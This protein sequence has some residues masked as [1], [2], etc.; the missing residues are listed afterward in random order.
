V[1][2]NPSR[3]LAEPIIQAIGVHKVYRNGK[4]EVP[5]LRGVDLTIG[6][7]EM[8]AI[9]GP[10]GC[11]KTTLLNTLSGLDDLSA[12]RVIIEGEA[13]HDMS[14]KERTRYRAQRMGFVFQLFNLLP[15]LS[16]AEN[17]ELPL[18]VAGT[19]PSD[20]RRAAREAL[21]LVGLSGEDH[22]RPAEMSGGQQQRVS[23][24]RALVNEP[25]IVWADEPTG[26]LDSETSSDVMSLLTRLNSE[27]EQTFVLVT[28]D[29]A[30]AAV[31]DRLVRMRSGVV[32][33]EGTRVATGQAEGMPVSSSAKEVHGGEARS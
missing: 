7:G 27:K 17:V 6:R 3:V 22:K 4:V 11:G 29:P 30:V 16:A 26:S 2:E 19:R 9:M 1:N 32:E 15:V 28:H 8:V 12:G 14:D 5:A 31:A 20:A 13:L 10:S 21:E 23:I 24:A 33:D 18:L 25:A